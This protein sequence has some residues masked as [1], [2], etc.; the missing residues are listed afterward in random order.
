[1]ALRKFEYGYG[2]ALMVLVGEL[3]GLSPSLVAE[4]KKTLDG[5][6]IHPMSGAAIEKE[7]VR[8]NDLLRSS[9]GKISEANAHAEKL[10]VQYG[11][12]ATRQTEGQEMQAN[13]LAVNAAQKAVEAH[14]ADL[15]IQGDAECQV[16]HLLGSLY[17]Y[18]AVNAVDLD[19]VLAEVRAELPSLDMPAWAE[20]QAAKSRAGLSKSGSN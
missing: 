19:S 4:A 9:P 15:G 16:W 13:K 6:V 3:M 7:A 17:E 11:F 1:M 14:Q 8:M 12:L 2:N 18:C 10:K 5:E 20:A